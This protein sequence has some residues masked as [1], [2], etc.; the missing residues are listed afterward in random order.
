[1]VFFGTKYPNFV[2][3]IRVNT[4]NA[5]EVWIFLKGIPGILFPVHSIRLH[6]GHIVTFRSLFSKVQITV[7]F[8][9]N[10]S[11]CHSH[12]FSIVALSWGS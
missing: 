4:T 5:R 8:N 6:A 10:R 1:M 7:H 12:A 3:E 11:L 9:H 2:K